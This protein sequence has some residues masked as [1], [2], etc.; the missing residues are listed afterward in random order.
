MKATLALRTRLTLLVLVAVL[1]LIVLIAFNTARRARDEADQAADVVQRSARAVAIQTGQRL[2]RARA[3]LDWLARQPSVQRL[4]PGA[5]DPVFATFGGL[6]PE[7]TNLIT[8]RRDTTRVCSAVAPT[9]QSPATVNPALYL[10]PTLAA[11]E[12]TL[13]HLTRGV[14]TGRWIVFAAHPLPADATGTVPGVVALSIDLA[15]LRLV[16]DLDSLPAGATAQ[17]VDAQG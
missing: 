2:Q 1:P 14:F 4:D 6:F 5:C 9:P 17:I 10:A 11:G 15:A 7:Y 13:G 16:D 3:L 12:F 8:V